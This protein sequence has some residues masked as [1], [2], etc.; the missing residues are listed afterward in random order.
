MC[1]MQNNELTTVV[2]Q[3]QPS[4]AGSSIFAWDD[5]GGHHWFL[6]YRME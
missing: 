4:V 6:V 1:T 2:G 3:K 5:W